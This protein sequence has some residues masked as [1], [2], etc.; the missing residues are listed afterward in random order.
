MH[1]ALKRP[2]EA[3][4]KGRR[5]LDEDTKTVFIIFVFGVFQ[6]SWKVSFSCVDCLRMTSRQTIPKRIVE[7]FDT[8]TLPRWN[9]KPPKTPMASDKTPVVGLFPSRAT[10][11]EIP[12]IG[13]CLYSLGSSLEI[14][15][16]IIKN[17]PDKNLPDK[18][19]KVL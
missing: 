13:K 10:F 14:S 15:L 9:T 5:S 6:S 18:S 4:W 2:T 19:V 3:N 17:L 16:S 8:A 1:Y 12:P 7:S 11:G